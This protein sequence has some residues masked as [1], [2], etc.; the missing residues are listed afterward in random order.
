MPLPL[1]LPLRLIIRPAKGRIPPARLEEEGK[2][3]GAAGV[4]GY[5]DAR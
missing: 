3:C 5:R 2:R 4:G 1:V